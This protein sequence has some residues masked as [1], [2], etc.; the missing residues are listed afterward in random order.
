VKI[1][2]H[3]TKILCIVFNGCETW[4]LVLREEHRLKELHK[5]YSSPSIIKMIN[6]RMM[7]CA[8]NVAQMG[9][10]GMHIGNWWESQEERDH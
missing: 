5:F 8:G 2:I 4:F 1:R 9:R 10:R 3:K 6:S 7:N